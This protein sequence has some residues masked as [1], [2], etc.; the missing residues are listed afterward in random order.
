LRKIKRSACP[1]CFDRRSVVAL[2][3]RNLRSCKTI[4]SALPS[5]ASGLAGPEFASAYPSR[6]NCAGDRIPKR[7][8]PPARAT[9]RPHGAD[10]RRYL[11]A[12]ALDPVVAHREHAPPVGD[13]PPL[14]VGADGENR[15]RNVSTSAFTPPR[16]GLPADKVKDVRKNK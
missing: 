4:P 6:I 11:R 16:R 14:E 10:L 15:R 2:R 1:S 8:G 3:L 5:S 12:M 7:T 13:E 9:S